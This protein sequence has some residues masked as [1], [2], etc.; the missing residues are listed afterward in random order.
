[1]AHDAMLYTCTSCAE[2]FGSKKF[3]VKSWINFK[4]LARANL[5]CY[6]C[7]A[8]ATAREHKLK[9]ELQKT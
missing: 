9:V 5:I 1:M 8:R 6:S 3:D 7:D 2:E 4:T